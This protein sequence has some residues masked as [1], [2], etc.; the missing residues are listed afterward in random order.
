MRLLSTRCIM[1]KLCYFVHTLRSQRQTIFWWL[2]S[3]MTKR[4]YS[5]S[6]D[7]QKLSNSVEVLSFINEPRSNRKDQTHEPKNKTKQRA[8]LVPASPNTVFLLNIVTLFCE[9]GFIN[10]VFKGVLSFLHRQTTKL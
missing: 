1:K 6:Q 5:P 2:F 4:Y 8:R 9:L 7:F 10:K 3:H